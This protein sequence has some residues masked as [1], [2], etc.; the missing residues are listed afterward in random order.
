[1]TQPRYITS[2]SSLQSAAPGV[3]I[4]E[5]AP[6]SPIKGQRNRIAGF[7][8][9]CVRGPVGKA[10][11]CQ[12]YKRFV[13]VFGER[14]RNSKGGVIIG[15]VWKALQSKYWGQ[16][17][18]ARVAAAAAAYASINICDGVG[19]NTLKAFLA[20]GALTTTVNSVIE[21]KVAGAAGDLITI[22]FVAGGSGAGTLDETGFPAIVFHYATGTTT[23]T[24]FETAITASTNLDVKTPGTGANVFASP[25]DTLAATPLAGG[26]KAILT[27]ASY[28]PGASGNDLQVRIFAASNADPNYFNLAVKLYGRVYQYSNITIANGIDN[29]N[30]IIGN[31]D[32][33]LIRLTKLANGRPV[34]STA[35]TDGADINGYVFLGQIV[36]NI[37]SV[38]GTDG[39]IMDTDYTAT[40]GPM[41]ILNKT[42]GI[43]C[44]AVVGDSSA[45]I[46]TKVIALAVVASQRVWFIC[47]TDQTVSVNAAVTERST[48]FSGRASYWF[49][50]ELVA[51]PVTGEQIYVEPFL[52]PMSIITQT[53]P[54]V[55]PGDYDNVVYQGGSL[56]VYNE[57]SDPDR[58]F[59]DGGTSG[60]GG[61]SYLNRDLDP[62][63]NDIIL[64]GNALTCDF[65]PNNLDLDGRFMKDFLLDALAQ[66]LRG[67]QFKGNTKRNRASRAAAC[68]GFLTTLAKNDMYIARDEDSGAPQFTYVND[69]SVNS[70]NDQQNGL[71]R[72]KLIA[73]LIPKN[74][75]IELLATI[76]VDAIISEQ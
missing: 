31:D 69:S 50:H 32:A 43:H 29:T 3:F 18:V 34:N 21:A 26:S 16:I 48:L 15:Q 12:S 51:D 58:D 37:T 64:P 56:G 33:V 28:G 65:T 38:A 23:V 76:G 39:A 27:I 55:H 4:L 63:G 6:A 25:G 61:V 41:E 8:G 5:Q 9:T 57:L 30:S 14:D 1:M 20:L 54:D 13:D 74:K 75:Q 46:K 72:E 40:G 66:R 10:V 47:P 67:D 60:T 17:W 42:R 71:Q 49:N 19:G 70:T 68:S 44:C 45:A 73:V 62:A 22:Q 53:D 35:S 2:E 24:N 59:L 52:L 7:A 36:A 11:L